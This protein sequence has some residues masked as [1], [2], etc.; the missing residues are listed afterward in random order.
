[1]ASTQPASYRDP[2]QIRAWHESTLRSR[3]R[4]NRI[5]S[6]HVSNGRIGRQEELDINHRRE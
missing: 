6:E 1:M 4:K 2:L 3:H 5:N